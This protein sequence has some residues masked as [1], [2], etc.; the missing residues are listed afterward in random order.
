MSILKK[1]E[2]LNQQRDRYMQNLKKWKDTFQFPL[3]FSN[4]ST[5][6][7]LCLHRSNAGP[8]ASD[9]E[10]HLLFVSICT[11]SSP[12]GFNFHIQKM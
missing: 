11:P 12:A 4:S 3:T 6:F 8:P 5:N 10:A 2:I 1:T 9:L 7:P